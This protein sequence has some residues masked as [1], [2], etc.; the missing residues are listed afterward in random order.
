MEQLKIIWVICFIFILIIIGYSASFIRVSSIKTSAVSHQN[1]KG[2]IIAKVEEVEIRG[3]EKKL[4]LKN[5]KFINHLDNKQL[6]RAKLVVRTKIE[7]I[8]KNDQIIVNANL[9]PPPEAILPGG[10]N[11]ARYAFFQEISA[12]G[13]A[14]GNIKIIRK[15]NPENLSLI[16]RL[17]ITIFNS[18]YANMQNEH[19]AI[20]TALFLGDSKKID[21]HTYETIRISGIAHLLAISGMHIALVAGL[22]FFGS[23]IVF[24]KI[25]HPDIKVNS[26]KISAVITVLFSLF[27]LLLANAPISAQRAF[28]MT[29]LVLI[30]ILM[31]R[32]T[33]PLRTLS[34][35]AVVI[36]LLT[37]EALLSASLQMS[38]SACL[39]LV[40]GFKLLQKIAFFNFHSETRITTK[41]SAY[42]S[43]IILASLFTTLATSMF[44]I[45]HFKNFSTYSLITN[46]LVIPLTEFIIMPFGILGMMLI[47]FKLEFFGYYLMELGIKLLLKISDVISSFPYSIIKINVVED[48]CLFNYVLGCLLFMLFKGRFKCICLVF[49][50]ISA[51]KVFTHELPNIVISKNAKLIAIKDLKDNRLYLIRGFRERYAKKIWG[52]ELNLKKVSNNYLKTICNNGLC[53]I[54]EYSLLVVFKE[55]Q[56]SFVCQSEEKTKIIINLTESKN[57]TCK[58]SLLNI[59][60]HDLKNNGP[61]M[62]WI[63]ESNVHIKSNKDYIL[64]KPWESMEKKF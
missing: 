36:L 15:G 25:Y 55:E 51:Y 32:E 7:S 43:S 53:D 30:G 5:V 10:F 23:S 45:F 12:I 44:I 18:F 16:A 46:L 22:I 63:N 38:F 47:P 50:I 21:N 57:Q 33:T 3:N 6:K 2:K 35:A 20:A 52:Q 28:T 40:Y 17:K 24:S 60:K 49:F 9:M 1:L 58:A 4:L 37:P 8:E 14:T 39:S 34:F 64:G 62:I 56:L 41:L 26:K 42:F 11:Y 27:Y 31:D 59:E 13:Y 61:Y 54:S 48:T 19:A 29:T